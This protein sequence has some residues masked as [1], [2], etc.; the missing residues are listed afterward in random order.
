MILA[1][2][3][4]LWVVVIGACLTLGFA[5]CLCDVPIPKKVGD[6]CENSPGMCTERLRCTCVDYACPVTRC[7]LE[8]HDGGGCPSACVCN[9]VKT[10]VPADGQ[11]DDLTQCG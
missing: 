4:D 7:V 2:Q 10:C 3:P 1:R 11:T 6:G 9:N 8:C 5:S